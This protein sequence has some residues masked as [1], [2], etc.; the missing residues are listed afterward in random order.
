MT[1]CDHQ[2]WLQH[3]DG[4]RLVRHVS[5]GELGVPP[6]EPGDEDIVYRYCPKCGEKLVED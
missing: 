5:D 4:Y 3:F 2:T 1:D 6:A